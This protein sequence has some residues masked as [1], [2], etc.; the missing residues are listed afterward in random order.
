MGWVWPLLAAP[1]VGSL[2]G[3]LIRRLPE[4]RPVVLTRSQCEQCRAPIAAHDLVPLLSYAVLHGAC[5]R[6]A[7]PIDP[8]HWRVELAALAV[9]LSAAACGLTGPA[10]WAACGLGWTLLALAWIDGH[11]MV[12]PDALTLPLIP[13]G[14]LATL[15]LNP[16]GLA[17][18]ALAVALGY[19]AFRLVAWTYRRLRGWEGLGE[20]DAKLLAALGA[21]IGLGGLPA[22]ILVAAVAGLLW[23]LLVRLRGAAM[24]LTTAL[25]F[26]PF[27][28]LAGWAVLL[29]G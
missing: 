3:V 25:P 12:L 8:F 11:G 6:C 1:F 7:A 2:L 18:H 15:W 22:V 21:W 13:A 24:G 27:L 4:G 23:A 26:G 9:P 20:G 28:A 19:T 10:L 5:R 16:G 29:W 17:D 14:L